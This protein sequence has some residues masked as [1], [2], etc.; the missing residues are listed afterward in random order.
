MDA[1]IRS[2]ADWRSPAQCPLSL[3]DH[4]L[5]SWITDTASLTRKLRQAAGARL[6]LTPFE[7]KRTVLT[8]EEKRFLDDCEHPEGLRRAIGF[9]VGTD[10]WVFSSTLVPDPT[11]EK[12]PWLAELGTTPLGDRVFGEGLGNRERLEIAEMGPGMPFYEVARAHLG[13]T[14]PVSFWA[15]RSLIRISGNPLLVLDGFIGQNGPWQTGS[16]LTEGAGS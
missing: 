7:E 15:R 10:L 2:A 16:P 8:S 14:P 4:P 12:E 1:Q 3:R 13:S 9:F 5:W 6:R 11:L